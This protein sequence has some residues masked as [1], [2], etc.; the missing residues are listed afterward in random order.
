MKK[1]III[2][3]LALAG[4]GCK[5]SDLQLYNPNNP[6][7]KAL[8]TKVGIEYYALGIFQ[9]SGSVFDKSTFYNSVM[10]DEQISSVGNFGMRFTQQ[11][12]GITL[13]APY[14]TKV[15][16]IFGVTQQVQLQSLNNFAA[17]ASGSNAF[18]FTW[19]DAYLVNG[20]A[21]ILLASLNNPV[22]VLPANEKA[23]LQAWAYWWKGLA[24]SQIG[25]LYSKGIINSAADGSTNTNYVGHDAI[26][27]EANAN[28]DKAIALLK[29]INDTDNDYKTTMV[30]ITPSF[31]VTTTAIT[32]SMWVRNCYTY[33]AR[34][35][36]VNTKVAAM[37][38][39]N[40]A[41]V[42]EL[43]GKGLVNGDQAF[44]RGM[45]VNSINDLTATT[46][47]HPFL[48]NNDEINPGWLYTSERLIQDFKPGDARFTKGISLLPT[49]VVNIRSRGIQFGSRYTPTAIEDGGYWSTAKAHIGKHFFAG[50]WEENA[51]MLAEVQIRTGSVDAGLTYIDQV[52]D[53]QGATLAH[54]AGTGLSQTA[55]LEELRRERRIGLF[56]RGV[57]FVDARRWGVTAPASAGGGRAN[58][59]VLVPGNLIGGST[60][61]PLPCFI[62][63]NYMDYWDIP[64]D[65]TAYNI[66]KGPATIQ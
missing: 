25:S 14:N 20:Q 15:P 33:E 40:W 9:Q 52:R 2:F 59:I 53:A 58:A 44:V 1:I 46:Q 65:E 45:D 23:T 3:A 51:L 43:A 63:Y 4:A 54:V 29:A 12:L 10:G 55:A 18:Q 41:K 6:S 57:A 60:F 11:A 16:N 17:D 62:E 64:V 5:K 35:I 22:L 30:A 24:Y 7:L 28:F 50:S 21:N 19:Q 49:P 42:A 48:W 66:P 61:K 36:L 13:P 8:E 38:P 27:T 26:I 34:N 37:T 31:N 39:A 47:A 56:L 32:P